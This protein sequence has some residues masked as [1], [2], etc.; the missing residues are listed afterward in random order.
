MEELDKTGK[1]VDAEVIGGEFK[2]Y[3]EYKQEFDRIIHKTAEG[4]V[5]TGYMLRIAEDTSLIREAGYKNMEEFAKAEYGIDKSQASRF[6]NINRTFSEGGY[7]RVLQKRYQGM[8]VAKL[9]LMLTLP[10]SVNEELTPD[11]SKEE[12][13]AVKEEIDEEKKVTELEIWMEGEKESQAGLSTVL[14]KAVHQMCEDDPDLF[15]VFWKYA[16]EYMESGESAQCFHFLLEELA[17][18]GNAIRFVRIQGTGRVS[19]SFKADSQ[20][21]SMDIIRQEIKET[22]HVRE[23]LEILWRMAGDWKHD[24]REAW[25]LVYGRE[26]PVQQEEKGQAKEAGKKTLKKESRVVKAGTQETEKAGAG[27]EDRENAEAQITGQ[28]NVE[29]Y[30]EYLPE[31][32]EKEKVAPVQPEEKQEKEPESVIKTGTEAENGSREKDA[33]QQASPMDG[34]AVEDQAAEAPESAARGTEEAAGAQ[35]GAAGETKEAAGLEGMGLPEPEWINTG[36]ETP[37][38]DRMA[39]GIRQLAVDIANA[40]IENASHVDP[41]KIRE[42]EAA[43]E[44]AGRLEKMIGELVRL[45]GKEIHQE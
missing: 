19:F 7:S 38:L 36:T 44:N 24:G 16:G 33:G 14:E 20:T 43:R 12:I 11:F 35:E 17:P 22:H 4:F 3:A 23:I 15:L 6:I 28:M 42:L 30:P 34:D 2:D 32:Y 13:R 37:S 1:T 45:A 8:G 9:G 10:E 40:V 25:G 21:F 41:G 5:E 39:A 27:T 29:D 18:C 26:F 31:G